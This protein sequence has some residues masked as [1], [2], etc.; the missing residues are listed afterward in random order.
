MVNQPIYFFEGRFDSVYGLIVIYIKMGHGKSYVIWFLAYVFDDQFPLQ[1][2][3]AHL[4][5]YFSLSIA[6]TI[7]IPLL[8]QHSS[9]LAS[10][11][12][13]LTANKKK[14]SNRSTV[15]RLSQWRNISYFFDAGATRDRLNISHL[16]SWEQL[17]RYFPGMIT[18]LSQ[19]NLKT[20]L[21]TCWTLRPWGLDIC[22]LPSRSWVTVSIILICTPCSVGHTY[23]TQRTRTY[24]NRTWVSAPVMVYNL[25]PEP[26]TN[27]Y[28]KHTYVGEIFSQTIPFRIYDLPPIAK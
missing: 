14:L 5:L 8:H 7:H 12:A 26:V 3:L 11:P 9:L 20:Y 1:P 4:P 2:C 19:S 23:V 13:N 27:I 21:S 15:P 24:L 6:S 25:V 28:K 10:Q 22:R 18:A 16:P 17:S